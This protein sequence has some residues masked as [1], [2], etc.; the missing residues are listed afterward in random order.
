MYSLIYGH[1]VQDNHAIINRPKQAKQQAFGE[2]PKE[3]SLILKKGK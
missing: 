1:K 3:D 2:C